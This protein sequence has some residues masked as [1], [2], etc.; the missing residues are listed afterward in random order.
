MPTKVALIALA[1]AATTRGRWWVRTAGPLP[2]TGRRIRLPS[3]EVGTVE[4]GVF[5]GYRFYNDRMAFLTQL[6]LLEAPAAG[7]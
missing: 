2:A 3:C 6:G 1:V 7:Q 4:N 5:T